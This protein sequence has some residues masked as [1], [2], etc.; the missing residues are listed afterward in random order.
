MTHTIWIRSPRP[1]RKTS[2]PPQDVL[3]RGSRLRNHPGN[4]ALQHGDPVDIHAMLSLSLS[5]YLSIYPSISRARALD[6]LT[7]V[8]NRQIECQAPTVRSCG[9]VKSKKSGS[10][11]YRSPVLAASANTINREVGLC[12]RFGIVWNLC[13]RIRVFLGIFPLA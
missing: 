4:G 9:T 12:D 5:P 11:S 2:D 10:F 7:C 6:C 13:D 3:P 8:T 1:I